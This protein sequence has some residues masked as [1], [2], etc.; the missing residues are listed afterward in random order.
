VENECDALLDEWMGAWADFVEF[1][2]IPVIA[3]AEAAAKFA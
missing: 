2:V 3:S 1:E